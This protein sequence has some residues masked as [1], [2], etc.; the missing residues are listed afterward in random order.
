MTV[1]MIL[2]III[3]MCG[4]CLMILIII[5]MSYLIRIKYISCFCCL[6]LLK[7]SAII[8]IFLLYSAVLILTL[9]ISIIMTIGM[10][11]SS[12]MHIVFCAL[13]WQ[14]DPWETLKPRPGEVA[15]THRRS[16]LRPSP[17]YLAEVRIPP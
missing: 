14:L 12:L 11:M 2:I 8:L 5:L 4:R 15:S 9:V 13:T 7:L 16:S 10:T 6:W 3:N 1:H 17:S